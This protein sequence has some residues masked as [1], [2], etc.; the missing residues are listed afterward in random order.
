MKL[1]GHKFDRYFNFDVDF[2]DQGFSTNWANQQQMEAAGLTPVPVVH[3]F[4]NFEIDFYMSLGKYPWLALG[5][6]Q[7]KSFDDF[8]YAMDRIKW[9]DSRVQLD[10]SGA[11][12]MNG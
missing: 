10:G 12:D 8:R 3:N 11:V 5:S 7:S 9:K 6:A 4:F 1:W 2:S